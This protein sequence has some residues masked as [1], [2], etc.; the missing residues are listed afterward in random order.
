MINYDKI[1]PEKII[2]VYDTKTKMKGIL[3]LDNLSRGPGKGGIRMTPT[4]SV[5]EVFRLAR[6]M[7]YKNA[8]ADLPFGGAKSGIIADP[9]NMT[10]EEKMKIVESFS[11]AIKAVCPEQYIAAPDINMGEEEMEV[12]ANANGSMQSTTGK[13]SHLGGLPHELGSTGYGVFIATLVALDHLKINPEETT[14]AVE[15][16]GNVGTFAAKFL[17]EKG[18]KFVAV[19]D[20]KGCIENQEGIN[21]EKIKK[22]KDETG[23]ILNYQESKIEDILNVK[24]D[25]L[26]TAAVPDLIKEQD[27]EKLNFNLIVQGSNIPTTPE[28]EQKLHEKNILVIPD[29]VA[30]S[31]GVISSYIEYIKGTEKEMFE[32]IK[33]KI[34]KNTKLVLEKSKEKNIKPRDAALEIAEERLFS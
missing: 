20:S 5:E 4:V 28:I 24:A 18:A 33:E 25:I 21:Y 15:G 9:K 1:G 6:A 12:F 17:T 32:L 7:T 14:F 8:L 19:S 3:V 23:S 11:K 2:Q 34:G 22:I 16:F 10:R 29:F 30:N 27:I 31:G 13:P 26:I